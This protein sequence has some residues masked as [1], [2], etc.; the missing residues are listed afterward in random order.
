MK[1]GEGPG[2]ELVLFSVLFHLSL[3]LTPQVW[4]QLERIRKPCL[5]GLAVSQNTSMEIPHT[6]SSLCFTAKES[7]MPFSR[8]YMLCF[9]GSIQQGQGLQFKPVIGVSVEGH[10]FFPK[11]IVSHCSIRSETTSLSPQRLAPS[12]TVAWSLSLAGVLQCK[13]G[14]SSA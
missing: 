2:Y 9:L 1:A 7:F 8:F 13:L 12:L 4:L 5:L 10:T 3:F 14:G 6:R 11:A